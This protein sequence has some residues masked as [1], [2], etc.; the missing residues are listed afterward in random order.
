VTATAPDP[1]LLTA[2]A[3]LGNGHHK[4]LHVDGLAAH[5]LAQQFGTPLYVFA[6]A[7]LDHQLAMV[8]AQFGTAVQVLYSIKANPNVAV[9]QRLRQRGARAE[10]ASLGELQVARAAGHDP[11]HLRWA[12]PAKTAA[13][14]AAAVAAGVG[15]LHLEAPT[16]VAAVAAAARAAGRRQGVAVRV[17]FPGAAAGARLRMAGAQSRFGIDADQVPAVLRAIAAAPELHLRGLHTYAGT[18]QFD[19]ASFVR[20]AE[21]LVAAASA[22]ER[23]LG[24]ALDELHL[25]GG[26]GVPVFAGDPSFDLAAAGHGVRSLVAHADRPGRRW[27]L[28]LGRYLVANAGVYLVAVVHQKYSGGVLQVAVDGG[29]HHCAA[30]CGVGSVVKR[31]PLLVA[32]ADLHPSACAPVS[33][34]GPLCT[35]A[36]QFGAAVPLPPLGPGDLLAVLAAGAYGLTYSPAAFLSHPTPAE[37]LVAD[38]VPHLVRDRGRPEDALRGQHW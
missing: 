6:A 34:G 31:P 37:V 32:A 1:A 15:C 23:E 25:G 21:Q 10:I 27:Y 28:E 5:A 36:D 4:A 9:V 19:A 20:G 30:A 13:E 26:F 17:H 8:Q 12:G 14:L 29:L 7:A 18:Q 3:A 38:G 22:F 2:L 24:L 11:E 16:E 35:P 33:V